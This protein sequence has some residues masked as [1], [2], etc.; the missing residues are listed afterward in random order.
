MKKLNMPSIPLSSKMMN[1]ILSPEL[2]GAAIILGIIS[3]M[4]FCSTF[5]LENQLQVL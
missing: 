4:T 1:M 2:R 3:V 5:L